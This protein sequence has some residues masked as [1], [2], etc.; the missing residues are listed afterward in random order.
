MKARELAEL[1]LLATRPN[2]DVSFARSNSE[3]INSGKTTIVIR[4]YFSVRTKKPKKGNH[5]IRNCSGKKRK[6][7]KKLR[8]LTSGARSTTSIGRAGRGQD[9]TFGNPIRVINARRNDPR[10]VADVLGAFK[11]YFLAEVEADP[12]FRAKVLALR[13]KRLGCFCKPGPCHGDIMAEWID[14]Q[15]EVSR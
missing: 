7:L 8:S 3:R 6:L 13:G 10:H 5:D 1:L 9:G 14:S 4:K 15:P 11:R 12:E 2:H